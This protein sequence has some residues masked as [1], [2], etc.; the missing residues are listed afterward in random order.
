MPDLQ[1]E[2]EDFGPIHKAN[3]NIGKLNIVGG[4]NASG[5]STASKLLYCFLLA[6][7]PEGEIPGRPGGA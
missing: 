1:L 2:I 5:K 4:V 6:G 7:S 3:I